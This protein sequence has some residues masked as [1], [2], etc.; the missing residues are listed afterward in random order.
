MSS[1]VLDSYA[2]LALIQQE[3]GWE[4]VRALLQEATDRKS[5]LLMSVINMAEVKYTLVRR[6][7][8]TPQVIAAIE[9]LPIEIASAD[10]SIDAVI[11]LK[12]NYALSLADCFAA[13]VA[14]ENNCPVVTGDP[15]FRKLE[16]LVQVEW[17]AS[18]SR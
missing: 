18:S 15:E 4:R 16:G 3:R 8:N 7:R 9:A 5:D 12:A 6:G 1:Y 10:E 11:S 13:A 14:I 17:V 2:L